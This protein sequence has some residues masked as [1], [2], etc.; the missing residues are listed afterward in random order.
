MDAWEVW[1]AEAW[2]LLVQR[3]TVLVPAELPAME[4]SGFAVPPLAEPVGQVADHVLALDDGSRLHVHTY[5]SG[6]R[7]AH[8]DT[9]DPGRSAGAAIAHW[10]LESRSGA[11]LM[12]TLGTTA[13]IFALDRLKGA[14][15]DAE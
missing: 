15:H 3:R 12:W 4:A 2:P 5:A 13:L 11:S 1:L 8:R 9:I 10:C 7:I 6:L 14:P